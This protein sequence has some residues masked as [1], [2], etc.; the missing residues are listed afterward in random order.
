M[1]ELLSLEDYTAAS[2][3]RR[4]E[5]KI[6]C[7]RRRRRR[8]EGGVEA[9]GDCKEFPAEKKKKKE[10][11]NCDVVVVDII[12]FPSFLP[13]FSFRCVSFFGPEP[14][15]LSLSHTH[16]IES[17]KG[18]RDQY[19]API[20]VHTHSPFA[21][22]DDYDGSDGGGRRKPWD[23]RAKEGGSIHHHQTKT[24]VAV[25]VGRAATTLSNL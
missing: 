18:K 24:S 11:G 3:K 2:Q 17:K 21:G 22:E 12:D 14:L 13:F 5:K 10:K 1:K 25:A 6:S 9:E 20:D 8:R 23:Q 19:R 16:T 7:S 15:V 4:R